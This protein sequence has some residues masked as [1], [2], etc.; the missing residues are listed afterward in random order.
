MASKTF[1]II[2]SGP[3]AT[4]ADAALLRGV[5]DELI[6]VNDAWRLCKG[7]DG[8]YFNDHIYGTDM[9]WWKWAFP[10]IMQEF[11]GGL[12]TQIKQWEFDPA[13]WGIHCYD[14]EHEAG[15]STDPAKIRT[16]MNSGYAAINVALHMGAK[17]I[18]LLGFDAS[19]EDGRLAREIND[20]PKALNVKVDY[21]DFRR[22]FETIRPEEYGLEI[23]NLSR[24]TA[25]NCFPLGDLDQ[26]CAALS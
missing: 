23:I 18:Y 1:G 9:K 6:A 13:E 10:A 4:A 7:P 16:G 14:S 5:V 26:L 20:R 2:A 19:D 25:L 17:L 8:K 15:L 3:S 11:D 12:Y 22:C 21:R 24:R